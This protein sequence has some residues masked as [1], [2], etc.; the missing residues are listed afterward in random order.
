MLCDKGVE[1]PSD[2]TAGRVALLTALST[3]GFCCVPARAVDGVK[4][5]GA[6]GLAAALL[7]CNGM[8]QSYAMHRQPTISMQRSPCVIRQL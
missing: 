2:D 5:T 7:F 6:E 3:A 4:G 1:D 8:R